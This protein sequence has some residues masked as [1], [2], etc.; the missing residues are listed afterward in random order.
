M[1]NLIERVWEGLCSL[2]EAMKG[3]VSLTL[4]LFLCDLGLVSYTL[5]QVTLVA[6]A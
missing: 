1:N 4:L 3:K 2:V 5:S 6:M